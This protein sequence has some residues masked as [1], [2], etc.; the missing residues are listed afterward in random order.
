[1]VIEDVH[2]IEPQ[3]VQGLVGTGDQILAAAPVAV[4]A[5]PHI[6]SGLGADDEF[7]PIGLEILCQELAGIFLGASVLGAIV[8]GQIKLAD[9]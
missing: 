3:T 8:V 4:R 2:I 1:M 5:G 6:I 9:S 7:I